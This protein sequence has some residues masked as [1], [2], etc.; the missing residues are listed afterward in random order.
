MHG[1]TWTDVTYDDEAGLLVAI[2]T[3]TQ[4]AVTLSSIIYGDGHTEQLSAVCV[5]VQWI[6]LKE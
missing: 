2:T 3:Y 5:D 6:I 1:C 4:I